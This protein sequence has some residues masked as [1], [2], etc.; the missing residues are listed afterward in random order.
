MQE[1]GGQGKT[2]Q[3]GRVSFMKSE[4]ETGKEPE[5]PPGQGR[6]SG[7][8]TMCRDHKGGRSRLG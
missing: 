4:R 8:S 2:D 1:E 6:L 3:T 5:K 7:Q